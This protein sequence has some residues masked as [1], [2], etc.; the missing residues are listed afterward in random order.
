VQEVYNYSEPIAPAPTTVYVESPQPAATDTSASTDS[1]PTVTPAPP[2]EAPQVPEPDPK[3]KVSLEAFAS[4]RDAFK[5]G[6]Y[7]QAQA[8]VDKA[9]GQNPS[10]PVMHEFRALTLFAQGKYQE[11][12]STI[13]AV[14]AGGP[15]WNW[16]TLRSLY[17]DP[18]T[19]TTQLRALEAYGKA[20]P[21]DPASRFL[22]AYEYMTIRQNDAAVR[23][24]E[25]V[26]RLSPNDQLAP[27]I[28]KALKKPSPA[29]AP[30]AGT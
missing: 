18:A 23:M 6:N 14:L 7:T 26:T 12:A 17:A 29:G 16:E 1:A 21:T 13:Y 4:A 2:A 27:I 20:H 15:G 22:L 10:D 24:L 8:L 30:A 25:D 5:Q 3:V 28:L 19:F 9:I 11:A